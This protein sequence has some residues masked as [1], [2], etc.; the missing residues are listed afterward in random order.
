[1][2]INCGATTMVTTKYVALRR[3]CSARPK[4]Q[5]VNFIFWLKNTD[6]AILANEEH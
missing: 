6:L 5:P 4:S 3:C 1:M 2:S